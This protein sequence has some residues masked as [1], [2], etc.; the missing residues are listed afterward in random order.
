MTEWG[1]PLR[2]RGWSVEAV[3]WLPS[4]ADSGLVRVRGRWVD[5]RA[6]R[7]GAARARAAPRRA[8]RAASS[9]CP[10]RASAATRR[11]G[12]ATY[13]VP[14]A[15]MD[16][17]PDELWLSW[18]S[19]ARAALPAPARGFE[20]PA[21]PAAPVAAA[22]EPEPEGEVIDRA[23]LAERRA[24]RAE[25]AERAQAERAAEALK[26]VEVLELRVGGAG[27]AAR[28]AAGR[29]AGAVPSWS[30][31]RT[32]PRRRWRTRSAA[33]KRLR[34]ELGEQ[35]HRLRRSELLR[36]ADAVALAT[37]PRGEGPR[38]RL[39][40]ELALRERELADAVGRARAGG[41][42]GGA[43]SPP[44]GRASA[45]SSSVAAGPAC[46]A[47]ARSSARSATSSP[48]SARSWRRSAATPS[49]APRRWSAA[50]PSSRP[51]WSRSAAHTARRRRRWSRSAAPAVRPRPL[52]TPS[53]AR[54][55]PRSERD[56]HDRSAALE[57][58]RRELR[59]RSRPSAARTLRPR[60]SA[61][62]RAPRL[63]LSE[64][65]RDRARRSPAPRST[66]SS[67][68]SASPARR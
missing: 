24:R 50:C 13:L 16:P 22:P 30:R 39:Q 8:R 14:A 29:R 11:S 21:S 36:A 46:S 20:P 49:S 65:A 26:A 61:R 63:A 38:R 53:A 42:A 4:G 68:A 66:R 41:R 44:R 17:A 54:T 48:A 3:E 5:E 10:T 57:A 15:L 59:P 27:A 55:R 37:L 45:A 52:S 40:A 31:A 62:R 23:V 43:G 60:R 47:R 35:R 2:S 33:I 9:R 67:T 18:E 7:G 19:G 34:Q 28:G 64:S 32:L 56:R 51:L 25:A 6:P 1:P 12:A 58:E